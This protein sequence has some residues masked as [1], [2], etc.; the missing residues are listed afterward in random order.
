L[1]QALVASHVTYGA[2]LMQKGA[3]LN[4]KVTTAVIKHKWSMAFRTVSCSVLLC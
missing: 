4:T 2:L 1:V 3:S